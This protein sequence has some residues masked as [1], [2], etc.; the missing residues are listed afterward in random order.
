MTAITFRFPVSNNLDCYTLWFIFL[1]PEALCNTEELP[2]AT[3]KWEE[4]RL[5]RRRP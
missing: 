1:H 4:E 2:P 5:P 3:S